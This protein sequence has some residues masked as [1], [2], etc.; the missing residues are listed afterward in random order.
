MRFPVFV[1]FFLWAISSTVL[2]A[3]S[4]T[5][6]L[7]TSR[8][9]KII[10]NYGVFEEDG[11]V[12][13][14]ILE[15]PRIIPSEYLRRLC[16]GDLDRLK[17]VIFDRVGDF[18]DV[19]WGGLNPTTFMVP[20]NLSYKKNKEG[21]YILG[22]STPIVFGKK[23]SK[24]S[25]VEFPV[26]IAVY[27]KKKTYKIVGRGTVALK[28]QIAETTEGHRTPPEKNTHVEHIAIHSSSELEENNGD[29]INALSS[30]DMIRQLLA[31]AN[32]LPFSQTLQM[33]VYNLR[34]LKNR[35]DNQDVIEKIN[36]VLLE[37]T[38]KEKELKE[39]QEADNMA[40]K[41]EEQAWLAQQKQEEEARQQK[42][43][44]E[45]RIEEAKQQKRTVWMII[46]GVILIALYFGGNMVLKHIRDLKNQ[47][48]ILEMQQSLA[49]QAENEA[50]RRV[51]E[52]VRNQTHRMTDTGKSKLHKE[53]RDISQ[54][55]NKSNR[56]S[57]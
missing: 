8:K 3:T 19:E 30:M 51:R 36:D 27:E 55:Q 5:D 17:V 16:K 34:M 7:Y 6:T 11:N 38:A 22:Q 18:G 23:S 20:A 50:N 2:F 37:Y 26:F 57:I 48:S 45:T 35:I 14:K 56:K 33:E 13:F 4:V 46:G 29:I 9:D 43:E 41:A 1:V 42:Q 24:N 21:F 40:A 32:E 44:E 10:L 49:K 28:V 47:R 12:A 53:I 31:T 52:G 54:K 25:T 15:S 39:Q